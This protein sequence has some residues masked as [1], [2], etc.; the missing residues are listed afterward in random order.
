MTSEKNEFP[1][2]E[3]ELEFGDPDSDPQT[4]DYVDPAI[5]KVAR[6]GWARHEEAT[7]ERGEE[8]ARLL[9]E[10]IEIEEKS[11]QRLK[12]HPKDRHYCVGRL[13]AFKDVAFLLRGEKK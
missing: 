6:W 8:L 4:E 10:H 1:E 7:K 11:I 12:A 9:K 5:R 3:L 13:S 2:K